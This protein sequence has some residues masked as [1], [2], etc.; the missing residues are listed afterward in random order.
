MNAYEQDLNRRLVEQ[1]VNDIWSRPTPDAR[2]VIALQYIV[3]ILALA[4]VGV[5][6]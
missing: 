3:A 6:W 2:A 5:R 1:R 4:L